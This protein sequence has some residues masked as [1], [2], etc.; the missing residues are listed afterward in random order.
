MRCSALRSSAQAATGSARDPELAR[1]VVA[2]PARQHGEHARAVAQLARDG[3]REAVAAHRRGDLAGGRARRARTRARAPSRSCARPGS[4]AHATRSSA[5]TAPSSFAA[6]PAPAVGL[7][8]RQRSRSIG[9][10]LLKHQRR[11]RVRDV[12]GA[13]LGGVRLGARRCRPSAPGRSPCP[14]GARRARRSP[15]G[16][17]P[18]GSGPRRAGR[19]PPRTSAARACRRSGPPCGPTAV[20]IAASTAPVAG[21]GPS[22]IGNV[23]SRVGADQLG[24]AA[25]RPGRRSGSRRR[26]AAS[27]A[28][29]TTTSARVANSVRLTIRS[30]ASATWSTSACEPTT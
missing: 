29:T 26:S 30:P 12:G 13:V 25:A 18:R 7:T 20:S 21:H 9:G 19:A 17:R 4:A 27:C 16:R 11:E 3:A 2:A 23:A 8:I 5:S 28:P 22:G 15:A 10:R 24:A 6:R 14:R 1:E